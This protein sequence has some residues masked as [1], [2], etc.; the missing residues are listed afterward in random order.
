MKE[1]SMGP[2]RRLVIT[3]GLIFQMVVYLAAMPVPASAQVSPPPPS[4]STG[5]TGPLGAT[6]PVPTGVTGPVPT[7]VTGPAPTG[8][9]GPAV[10]TT[11]NLIVKLR[12]GLTELE[13][14]A[15]IT[16]NGGVEFSEIAPLRL[17][18]V[19]VPAAALVSSLDAFR[20]DPDVETADRDRVRD[21]EGTPNDPAYVDQWALP[22]IGWD[23][24]FGVVDPA[25]TAT[26]A[27]LDTGVEWTVGDIP[28]TA[29]WSAFGT[30]PYHD[31]HGHGTALASIAAATTDNTAGIAGVAYDGVSVQSV[32]VLDANG[33]GQDSDIIAGVV[34]AAENGAD[35]ILMGFSNPGFSSALQDAVDYA[36]SQGAVLVAATGN[37]GSS[38]PTYPAGDAKVIGV[39]AT[40]QAD[41]LAS[42]SNYGADTFIAAPGV[43]S[44]GARNRRLDDERDW[45]VGLRGDRGRWRCAARGERPG[46][47]NGVI[48]GRLA[49]NA[50]S[51]GTDPP[52]VAVSYIRMPPTHTTEGL[53]A[54]AGAGP[55]PPPYRRAD[56]LGRR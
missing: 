18:V 44:D 47:S 34:W 10:G 49:R 5:P 50:D 32:Q 24:A 53:D 16:R 36:W 14:A 41:A 1:S 56:A 7:G 43:G 4:G 15:V 51:S 28:V 54:A 31:P 17:H 39:S 46:A 19:A 38:S 12:S 45:Y 11:E 23:Q 40:D 20:A 21:A 2:G 52:D 13:Q 48:V 30:D 6:G 9:T 3:F 27:V 22:Q 55:E 29:G 26:I 37:D 8:A 35:V 42:F 25:G 33:E